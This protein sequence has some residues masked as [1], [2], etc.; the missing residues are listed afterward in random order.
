MLTIRENHKAEILAFLC[1]EFPGRDWELSMPAD[2]TGHESYFARSG[3]G[4]YFVKLG[5][6]LERYRVMFSLGLAPRI[7]S[8]GFLADGTS[9]IVQE[10]IDGHP[11]SRQDFQHHLV[12]FAQAIQKTHQCEKL[13]SLLGTKISFNHQEVGLERLAQVEQRWD[14]YKPLVT[15]ACAVFVDQSIGQLREAIGQFQ[16]IGL[17]ASHNDICNAN[18][19]VSADGRIYLID[20]ESMSLDDPALDVGA[21][22]W[23]YYP[24]HLRPAFLEIAG[25]GN[26]VGFRERMRIRMAVHCLNI[27]LPRENSF[28]YFD[29]GAFDNSLDDFRAALAGMENPQGYAE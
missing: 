15:P 17:V 21:I 20:Y 26:E 5:I 16:G 22:L 9:F 2:G 11:P 23:W 29:A 14:F 27:I 8:T 28:D 12:Q 10:K 4:D 19:L 1:R 13:R 3:S 25:Y 18:W 7:V 24:P 6:E